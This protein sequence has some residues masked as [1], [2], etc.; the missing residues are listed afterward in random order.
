MNDQAAPTKAR[1]P[2][3]DASIATRTFWGTSRSRRSPPGGHEAVRPAQGWVQTRTVEPCRSGLDYLAPR[4]HPFG[5]HVKGVAE[6]LLHP[7][8]PTVSVPLV[9]WGLLPR[10][11]LL[12]G[13]PR[14]RTVVTGLGDR[15]GDFCFQ[16]LALACFSLIS[17]SRPVGTRLR[18]WTSPWQDSMQVLTMAKPS[19]TPPVSRSRATAGR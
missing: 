4:L 19:P 15:A 1:C 6:T 7:Q 10:I 12:P 17:T 5:S 14:Q 13:S 16:P 9:G 11:L 2:F 3:W 18:Q 8:E